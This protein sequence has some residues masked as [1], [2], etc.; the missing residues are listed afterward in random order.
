VYLGVDCVDGNGVDVVADGA[1]YQPPFEPD[2]IVC[3]EV[4]E[5]A[6]RP[7]ALVNRLAQ[8]LSPGGTLIITCAGP[9]R[10][11]HSAVDGGRLRLGEHYCGIRANDLGRW[12][13]NAGLEVQALEEDGGVE[14]ARL[15]DDRNDADIYAKAVKP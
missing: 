4:L 12:L 13:I 9:G 10:A 11:P 3:C 14:G 7:Q 15:S 2:C 5:H 8:V 1:E 6:A